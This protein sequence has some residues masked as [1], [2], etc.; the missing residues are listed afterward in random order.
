MGKNKSTIGLIGG[1]V[2]AII[3][4]FLPLE[5]LSLEG[6]KCLSLSLLAIV[7]WAMSAMHPG[8]VSLLLLGG[9]VVWNVA[10][11]NIVFGLWASP[12][13]YLV[14]GGY[15]IASAV[16]ES[17]LGKRIAYMYILRYINSYSSII[18]GAYVLGFL[19]SFLIPHPW[20]RSFL[21]MSV[22]AVIIK[23]AGIPLREAANIG[24]AVFAGSAPTSTILLTG[25]SVINVIT[26]GMANQP[27]S[28]LGWA[29]MMGVPGI[30]ASAL[31][32]FLQLKIFKPS[33]QIAINKQE[34]SGQLKEMGPLS[35][36]ELR[37]LLWVGLAIVFWVTDSVHHVHPGWVA[38]FAA[39]ALSLP[40]IGAVLGPGSWNDVPIATLFFLTAALAIGVVGRHTGM[41]AWLASVVLPA[42]APTNPFMFAAF[43]A[44]VS[45][46][47]HMCLG[48]VLAVMGIAIPTMIQ[49]SASSG[50]NPL[51]PALI[52]YTAISIHF[53]LPFHHMNVLVGLGEKQGM[54]GDREVIRLGVPLTAIVFIITILVQ[55]PWWK[56]IGLL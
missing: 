25:D 39:I 17:G 15:L 23:S 29:W 54:Y 6:K 13:V 47:L 48:S 30:V 37:T 33:Q 50:M 31:T 12:I 5:G 8:Y 21:I 40:R 36:K 52:V 28:W 46:V 20:P 18:V 16:R 38:L 10:P 35:P 51:V 49:F 55:I 56:I 42:Q 9:Y 3:V 53:V 2:V 19:L 45:V 41:N 26:T 7:C 11:G 44:V 1:I 4:W 34:I 27:V 24:L 22:M 14:V 43:V 32:C